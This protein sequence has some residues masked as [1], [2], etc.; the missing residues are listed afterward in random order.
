[1]TLLDGIKKLVNI[2]SCLDVHTVAFDSSH[3]LCLL[4]TSATLTVAFTWGTTPRWRSLLLGQSSLVWRPHLI[5]EAKKVTSLSEL[6]S[7]GH[8]EGCR[9]RRP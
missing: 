9:I 5:E 4:Y 2:D 7:A 3:L 6:A 8:E 1:M